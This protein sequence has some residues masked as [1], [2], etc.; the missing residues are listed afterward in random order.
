MRMCSSSVS[1]VCA[2]I[3]CLLILPGC[4]RESRSSVEGSYGIVSESERLGLFQ[5]S[6]QGADEAADAGAEKGAEREIA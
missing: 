4:R 6:S 1:S 3:L 2:G 5:G